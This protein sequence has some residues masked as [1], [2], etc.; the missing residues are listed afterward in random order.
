MCVSARENEKEQGVCEREME[1][2]NDREQTICVC[3]CVSETVI[4]MQNSFWG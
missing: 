4:E 1:K 3:V 2:E